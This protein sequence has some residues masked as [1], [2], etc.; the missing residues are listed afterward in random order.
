MMTE[1]GYSLSVFGLVVRGII[2][3]M[4]KPV[5]P[6]ILIRG[7][8]D[9]ASGVALRLFHSGFGVVISEIAAPLT[10]RRFASFAEAVF[11][12]E[13]QVEGVKGAVCST[14][15]EILETVNNGRIAVK[16][17]P[18]AECS[19]QVPF[20]AVV[21]GRMLKSPKS[22]SLYPEFFTL[23]LGPGFQVGLN[24]NAVIET[25]R[26]PYLGRVYWHG[27][28][29]PDTGEPETVGP[30]GSDRVLRAP[31]AGTFTSKHEIGE[32][33]EAGEIIGRI[34][35]TSIMAP[36]KGVLRGLLRSGTPV[37]PGLKIGD[38]DP[39]CDVSLC[40]LAS[41]K[42]LAVGGG[43]LEAL[44]SRSESWQALKGDV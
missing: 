9:L 14:V 8:G 20:S 19:H 38:I 11:E 4:N 5:L 31:Q 23:G 32:I 39:R 33:V 44:L 10:V 36:F 2:Q 26:G 30:Y 15:E 29:Q 22:D 37:Q 41:D 18:T 27:S 24:C 7:G 1:S 34:A 43:V 16:V 40:S 28:A 6:L 12:G 35:D 42:S 21:D 25:N 17:D 13:W 3:A